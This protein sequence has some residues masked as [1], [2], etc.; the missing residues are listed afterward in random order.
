MTSPAAIARFI[1]ATGNGSAHTVSVCSNPVA[2]ERFAYQLFH[3]AAQETARPPQATGATRLAAALNPARLQ[4]A[5]PDPQPA[6]V[7][8]AY[9][10]WLSHL[11]WLEEVLQTLD[12]RPHDLTAVELAGLQA[13]A[14]A[15]ARFARTHQLCPH[16]EAVNP[17]APSARP[18]HCRR[19]RQEF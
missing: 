19:C 12:W 3:H 10:L 9:Q 16:C 2:L 6:P 17:R 11:L 15:R 18:A 8:V 13:L 7:P 1:P 5:G 14:R 4:Q